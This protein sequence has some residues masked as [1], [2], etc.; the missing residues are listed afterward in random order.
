MDPIREAE[1]KAIEEYRDG[2]ASWGSGSR[3]LRFAALARL[4]W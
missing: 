1:L 4:R 2:A 3:W